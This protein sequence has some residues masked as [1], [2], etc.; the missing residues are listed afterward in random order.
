MEEFMFLLWIACLCAHKCWCAPD[1]PWC[2]VA[3]ENRQYEL[4][5]TGDFMLPENKQFITWQT[6]DKNS[7]SNDI[8][9]CALTQTI[10]ETNRQ[11]KYAVSNLKLNH[12]GKFVFNLKF[13]N[14]SVEDRDTRITSL[15]WIMNDDDVKKEVCSCRMAVYRPGTAVECTFRT[16]D[17][18][19]RLQCSSVNVYP[20]ILCRFNEIFNMAFSK[21]NISMTTT[22]IPLN[23][24]GPLS[25]NSTCSATVYHTKAGNYTY[26]ISYQ[27]DYP[28]AEKFVQHN[29][30]GFI[31]VT[32]VPNVTVLQVD[33]ILCSGKT[34]IKVMC[35]ATD[36]N[37]K[38]V[39][40]LFLASQEIPATE[41]GQTSATYQIDVNSSLQKKLITCVADYEANPWKD[42][43]INDTKRLDL[44]WPPPTSPFFKDG[45]SKTKLGDIIEIN[46]G[47]NLSVT[48]VAPGGNPEVSTINV[49]CWSNATLRLN[50]SSKTGSV[51][52]T[53]FGNSTFQIQGCQCSAFQPVTCYN[54]TSIIFFYVKPFQG[55]TAVVSWEMNN[56]LTPVYYIIAV[57]LFLLFLP[58]ILGTCIYISRN[59]DDLYSYYYS[60][61][62]FKRSPST[63]H[64]SS[65]VPSLPPPRLPPRRQSVPDLVVPALKSEPDHE[66]DGDWEEDHTFLPEFLASLP[67]QQESMSCSLTTDND[68]YLMPCVVSRF[69]S[70]PK[71]NSA[72][73]EYGA[74]L[75]NEAS[76]S[77][78][79][80]PP[81]SL[82]FP[83]P[84][85]RGRPQ[86]PPE[87]I[88]KDRKRERRKRGPRNSNAVSSRDA[89]RRKAAEN[90]DVTSDSS[91]AFHDTS[92]SELPNINGLVLR[93]NDVMARGGTTLEKRKGTASS[94]Q[95]DY[96]IAS[97]VTH[98]W[99]PAMSFDDSDSS[100]ILADIEELNCYQGSPKLPPRQ[101][102]RQ[103]NSI[104][105][106]PPPT[107]PPRRDASFGNH[108]PLSLNLSP[109]ESDLGATADVQFIYNDDDRLDVQSLY[110]DDDQLDLQ[111]LFSNTILETRQILNQATS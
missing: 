93:S 100:D 1:V 105:M 59:A 19:V 8:T 57:T 35:S 28:H 102:G 80:I 69:S 90:L 5:C 71:V 76:L 37:S 52:F 4:N 64:S 81:R 50:T 82:G 47:G 53:L 39:F 11:P 33:S 103:N 9:T 62:L 14:I 96:V 101:H 78:G 70:L 10:C 25:Y 87:R 58:I 94:P 77:V 106:V 104:N 61:M 51:S 46:R 109:Q 6:I 108:Q 32:H 48:C 107:S 27:P 60:S 68:D 41:Y 56:K 74:H 42:F 86:L 67:P 40:K 97:D 43:S 65:S 75:R 38:P 17:G 12:E 111:P 63:R 98:G 85:P 45:K 73:A 44:K 15:L 26:R 2:P 95:N 34:N 92:F 13:K 21:S 16:F 3:E 89:H 20:G 29:V 31:H 83:P 23:T 88:R 24:G 49:Q 36:F 91:T 18:G 30:S 72:R 22:N 110:N 99:A 79:D 84:P 55:K 66:S 54:A 7:K